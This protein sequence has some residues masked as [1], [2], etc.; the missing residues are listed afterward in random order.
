MKSIWGDYCRQCIRTY[1]T[2]YPKDRTEFKRGDL[3]NRY[4]EEWTAWRAENNYECNERA[5]QSH[6]NDVLEYL[7]RFGRLEHL[8]DGWYRVVGKI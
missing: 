1:L 3:L 2:N 4:R 7:T 6:F 8:G 5:L